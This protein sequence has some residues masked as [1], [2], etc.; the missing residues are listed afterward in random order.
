MARIKLKIKDSWYASKGY[1]LN[2][3]GHWGLWQYL[4][5]NQNNK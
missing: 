3:L 2:N 4:M 5:L 1:K